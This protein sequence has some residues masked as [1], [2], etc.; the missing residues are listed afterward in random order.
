MI[1]GYRL[2]D[3]IMRKIGVSLVFIAAIDGYMLAIDPLLQDC[4][5]LEHHHAT[6]RDRHLGAGLRVAADALTFLAHH[7]RAE[8]REFDRL[9]LLQAVG[10][11]FQ[12]QLDKSR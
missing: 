1:R 2:S 7:E 12:H 8:R 4:R 10:D 6:R 9:A 5:R 3:T 11:L